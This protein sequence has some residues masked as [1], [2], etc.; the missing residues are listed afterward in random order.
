MADRHEAQDANTY[1]KWTVD[2]L[3]EDRFHPGPLQINTYQLGCFVCACV[4]ADVGF[5]GTA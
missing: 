5:R 4:C 2:Y 3:K 1:A